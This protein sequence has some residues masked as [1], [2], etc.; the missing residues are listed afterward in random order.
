M[1]KFSDGMEVIVLG[2]G[3]VCG[4]KVVVKGWFGDG[5]WF[6]VLWWLSDD[7][8]GFGGDSG[9][10]FSFFVLVFL[11]VVYFYEIVDRG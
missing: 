11:L 2:S 7:D 3:V 5:W 6:C 10:C 4:S 8:D 9:P 1:C